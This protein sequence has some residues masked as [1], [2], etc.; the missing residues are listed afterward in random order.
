MPVGRAGRRRHWAHWDGLGCGCPGFP[1]E[2]PLENH[3]NK[4]ISS[5][6]GT[7]NRSWAHHRNRDSVNMPQGGKLR[8]SPTRGSESNIVIAGFTGTRVC[9]AEEEISSI[10]FLTKGHGQALLTLRVSQDN[11][12]ATCTRDRRQHKQAQRCSKRQKSTSFSVHTPPSLH[13]ARARSQDP[14]PALLSPS[15]H[16]PNAK[17]TPGTSL[18]RR[19]KGTAQPSQRCLA[20][21]IFNLYL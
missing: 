3:L 6:S 21:M 20:R 8:V 7:V 16:A 2:I 11:C 14:S 15:G 1:A 18:P 9:G 10:M 19:G 5:L 17:G 13:S 4:E 12:L